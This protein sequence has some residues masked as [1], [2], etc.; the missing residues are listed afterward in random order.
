MKPVFSLKFPG[1]GLSSQQSGV[2][3]KIPAPAHSPATLARAQ[4]ADLELRAPKL[5][6]PTPPALALAKLGIEPGT[7][8]SEILDVLG[9]TQLAP[10]E[11]VHVPGKVVYFNPELARTCG[12]DVPA[13]NQLTPELEA[14]LVEALSWNVKKVG[15]DVAGRATLPG[16]ADRYGG[17]GIGHNEG[18]GR[19]AFLPTLNANIKGVGATPLVSQKTSY[20]HRHG[21]APMTEGFLEAIWGEV[22]SNLFARGSTRILAVIDT[23]DRT[24]WTDGGSERRALIVRLGDQVRPAHL[25]DPKAPRDQLR[26]ILER[27]LALTGTLVQRADD[28]GQVVADLTASMRGLVHAHARTAA[29]QFRWR[30][31][32]GALSP[33][34]M[35]LDGTQLDLGTIQSQPRTAPIR[36]LGHI[37]DPTWTFGAEHQA[38]AK[39]LQVFFD[40]VLSSMSGVDRAR[41]APGA[42]DLKI[43]AEMDRA[44]QRELEVQ[45]LSATGLKEELA[46]R[47]RT[48][49][50]KLVTALTA[51]LVEM[52]GLR[53]EGNVLADK[54][55][56][57]DVAVLDVFHLLRV[58]PERWFAPDAAR[59][60]VPEVMELLRP[61]VRGG[62][63]VE[64]ETRAKAERLVRDFIPLYAQLMSQAEQHLGG[65]YADVP[66]LRRSITARAAF[67]NEPIDRLYRADLDA[68]LR[69]AISSYEASGDRGVFKEV[70]DKTISASLRDVDGLLAQG[71]VRKI[72]GGIDLERRTIDGIDHAV[73]ALDDG[74]RR[75]MVDVPLPAGGGY[76]LTT[77]PGAPTLSEAQAQALRYRFTTDGWTTAQE[78]PARLTTDE[79][80]RRVLRFEIPML[81]SEVGRLEGVFHA[82]AGGEAWLKDGASNFR[83]YTF[84]VPDA[85]ELQRIR[86]NLS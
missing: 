84:A 56:V 34:N 63:H 27:S 38:R 50:P 18:A 12:F 61:I 67:E 20:D 2:P 66:S 64:K 82:S 86:D 28:S 72:P 55:V 83:G 73:R 62:P 37:S 21:G 79:D 40:T 9:P 53:N 3:P 49:Q 70:V 57:R 85:H 16:Y 35:E 47:L 48:K 33:S 10:V 68:T 1:L 69:G 22:N 41:F 54:E 8:R 60:T 51:S 42:R 77:L 39:Q 80:G 44:Y 11:L 26:P 25:L 65:L 30:V 15:E 71:G 17:F 81:P 6:V 45:L 59:P 36:T 4:A 31:T 75:L 13:S 29:E 74:K 14:Q 5:G 78:A 24:T 23:D 58:L 46:T 52:A 32:H 43:G 7:K 76:T 19:A